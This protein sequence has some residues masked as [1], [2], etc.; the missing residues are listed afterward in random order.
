[1]GLFSR[2]K[3]KIKIQTT[4]KDSFSGWLKCTHCHEL[5]HTREIEQHHHCCP[6]CDYHYR[7]SPQE[8]IGLLVDPDSFQELYADLQSVDPL[9]FVDSQ[10]YADRLKE[11]IEKTDSLDA[12]IVGTCRMQDRRVA[13]GVM[14]FQ[15]MGGSMGSV[16]GEKITRHC[17]WGLPLC[18]YY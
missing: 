15:F 9:Q 18:T 16:V 1:M 8:R 14:N 10:P 17:T 13:L 11:S 5:I 6:K 12:M 7:L 3:A 2:T 4:K